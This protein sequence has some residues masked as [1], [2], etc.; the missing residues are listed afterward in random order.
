MAKD[1]KAIVSEIDELPSLPQVVTTIITL[2]NN[3]KSSADD[4]H[5]AL[6]RDPSLVGRI[7]KLVNSAFYGLPNRV[8]NVRQAIVLLGFST[9]RSLALSAAIFDFFGRPKHVKFSRV[10]FWAHL[11]GVAGLARLIAHREAGLN[12]ESVFAAGLLHDMGKLVLDRF[13]PDDFEAVFQLAQKEKITF[14]DAERE[15]LDTDHEEIGRWLAERWLLPSEL[16]NAIGHHHDPVECPEE[17]RRT[18]AVCSF[19]DFLANKHRAVCPGN[20]KEPTLD[21]NVWALLTI[22]KEVIPDLAHQVDE[23]L[24][25]SERLFGL[26]VT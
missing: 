7:L 4:L 5:G 3:P 1:L 14:L 10:A 16:I 12:E 22:Q 21:P 15:L 23:E 26:V 18:A 9:V 6:E 2:I 24:E 20:F 13:A 8:S 19:A 17:N 11:V 25:R